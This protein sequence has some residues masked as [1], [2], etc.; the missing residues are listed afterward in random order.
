MKIALILL[1]T[2]A[3]SFAG[4]EARSETE[5]LALP[6]VSIRFA[7]GTPQGV[8]LK[9]VVEVDSARVDALRE[10]IGVLQD[11]VFIAGFDFLVSARRT[12]PQPPST[13]SKR[14]RQAQFTIV[15]DACGC[16]IWVSR[17]RNLDCDGADGA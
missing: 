14:G 8:G 5:L 2:L 1:T 13:R 4:Q 3:T 7:A 17:T 6:K 12:A 16:E 15:P 9:V 10:R 11:I